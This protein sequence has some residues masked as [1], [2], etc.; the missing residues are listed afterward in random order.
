MTKLLENFTQWKK[1]AF[2]KGWQY[3][4]PDSSNINQR[5]AFSYGGSVKIDPARDGLKRDESHFDTAVAA[6]SGGGAVLG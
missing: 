6:A 1:N 2:I 5:P 3:Y 4:N